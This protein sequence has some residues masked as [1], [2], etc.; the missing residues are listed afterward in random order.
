MRSNT[1]QLTWCL[2]MSPLPRLWGKH[3]SL[4]NK[5]LENL[6]TLRWTTIA[7]GIENGLAGGSRGGGGRF[8]GGGHGLTPTQIY[9]AHVGITA[10][11]PPKKSENRLYRIHAIQAARFSSLHSSERFAFL[12]GD[13]LHLLLGDIT[14]LRNSCMFNLQWLLDKWY[15]ECRDVSSQNFSLITLHTVENW[16]ANLAACFD[17]H[18]SLLIV[19]AAWNWGCDHLEHPPERILQ[20]GRH[21]RCTAGA[22]LSDSWNSAY[23]ADCLLCLGIIFRST[24]QKLRNLGRLLH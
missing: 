22:L 10:P 15:A 23:F 17:I 9:E 4:K 3:G 7:S 8:S 13:P 20:Q 12:N 14:P 2:A 19:G 5:N 16:R 21:C 24:R 1:G 6:A 11:L 18:S